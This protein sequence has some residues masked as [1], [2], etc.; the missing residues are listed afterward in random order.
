MPYPKYVVTYCVMTDE[1]GANPF[2]HSLILMSEQ[3][4]ENAPIEVK[5]A[6]GFYSTYP[7]STTNPVIKFLKDLLGFKIDLQDSH[8]HLETEKLRYLDGQ[9]LR[10]ISFD[11]TQ[12][13]YQALH[14]KYQNARRLEQEA[15]GEYDALLRAE[16][17]PVNGHTRWM[18]EKQ[19]L[20]EKRH[21][22]RLFPFH[23]D[24]GFSWNFEDF[25]FF[26]NQSYTCKSRALDLL[27]DVDII[28]EHL[29]ANILGTAAAHA[30]PRYG[31]E[32][33]PSIQ[34]VSTGERAA[35]EKI[36]SS[37]NRKVHYNR[38]WE[39]SQLFWAHA[40]RMYS[41]DADSD[42]LQQQDDEYNLVSNMSK[43]IDKV[44]L[45]L[46][47][48]IASYRRDQN[49]G[50]HFQQ[51][52]TQLQRVM[53]IKESLKTNN[54]NQLDSS[55]LAS[56]LFFAEKTLNTARMTLIHEKM[57]YNFLDRAI[58]N[59]ALSDAL[60]GL[61]AIIA[62]ANLLTGITAIAVTVTA[63]IYSTYKFY[64][65]V[66]TELETVEMMSDYREYHAVN[67]NS[68]SPARMGNLRSN[69]SFGVPFTPT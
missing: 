10:G 8:G 4:D 47:K 46:L 24:W 40:P 63:G 3:T 45:L 69:D 54:S 28:D 52:R 35:E 58:E 27:R 25:G 19:F 16:G 39:S 64:K 65:A 1:A 44:E 33:L 11:V 12:E 9:G 22:Q 30:F 59:I 57:D 51:C 6:F 43:E 21:D 29:A 14:D 42:E 23:I 5:H 53:Q 48:K 41:V 55:S 2:W 49:S 34:L 66:K 7:S 37:G 56:R 20:S 13:K 26:T 38:S 68:V 15:I 36:D 61:I 50:Q 17:M 32:H 31:S 62:A 67:S 18:K 60:L